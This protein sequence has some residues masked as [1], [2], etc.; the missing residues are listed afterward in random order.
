MKFPAVE[1]ILGAL[2]PEERNEL[3]DRIVA[4][5]VEENSESYWGDILRQGHRGL[6]EWS[7]EELQN[8][9]SALDEDL[10]SSE[11]E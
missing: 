4:E 5:R 10:G 9:V 3:I 11:E 6:N 7:D 8:E 2:S 1:K